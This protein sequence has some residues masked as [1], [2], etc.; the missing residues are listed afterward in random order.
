MPAWAAPAATTITLAITSSGDTVASGGSVASGSV[1]TLTARVNAGTTAVTV[2]QVNFCDAAATYCSDIHLLGTAQ[3]TSAGTAVLKFIPG[4][5]SHSYKAVFVGTTSNAESASIGSA[6]IVTG[7]YATMTGI[8]Q[9]GSGGDYSLMATVTGAGAVTPPT[10]MVSFLDA[11]NGNSVL[12]TAMLGTGTPGL[13]WLNSQTPAVGNFP[14]SV[15]VG[16]FNRD[17]IPDLAVA[18]GNDNTLTVL[19]GKGDGT[20][21]TQA[22]SPATGVA[23]ACI[24]VRDFNGDGIPDLAVSYLGNGPGGITILLGKGD[25]TFTTVAAS[26]ATGYAPYSIAVGDFNGDGIP[27]LAAANFESRTVTVLLGNGDG[28]F[29]AAASPA[30]GGDPESIAV[31]DFNGDGKDDLAVPNS[32]DSTVTILLGN[33]DGTFTTAASPITGDQPVCV[34]V[35]DFNGDGKADLAVANY[36]NGSYTDPST[37]TILLGNGDGTFTAATSPVTGYGPQFIA[38][39]D[40]NGDGVP[41]LAVANLESNTVTVLLGKGDGTFIPVMSPSTGWYPYSL[42]VGDFNGN[43]VPD[44]AV[45]N[46]G[47]NTATVL[48]TQLTQTAAATASGVSLSGSGSHAVEASFS[49]DNDYSASVSGTILVP[50]TATSTILAITSGG[51][52]VTTVASGSVVTLTATVTTGSAAL[53]T[54]W[55]DLCDATAVYCTDIHLLGTAQLTSAGTAVLSFVP[56]I[57][58]HS[59]KAVFV[60]TTGNAKSA[61]NASPL[62]VTGKHPTTTTITQSGTTGNYTLTATVTG[63]GASV[64]PTGTVSFLDTSDSNSVLAMAPLAA[65]TTGLNWVNSQASPVGGQPQSVAV[66]DFNRDGI[67]DIVVGNYETDNLTVLLGKGDG[68]FTAATSPATGSLPSG[69]VV[70]DFN[71]DGIPDMAVTNAA[72]PSQNFNASQSSVTVLLG[73]GDGTFTTG[74][75]LTAGVSPVSIATGDFNGDD[76]ADLAVV[77]QSSNTLTIFL[78]KGDGTFSATPISPATGANPTAVAVGDFNGDGI[79]DL[80]VANSGDDTVTV[81]IGNGD[82]TFTAATSPATGGRPD[83][84]A[85]GDFN[86]DGKIDLAVANSLDNTVMVLLSNG[87]GTFTAAPTT[88]VAVNSGGTIAVG[89]FNGDGILDLAVPIGGGNTVTVLLGNGDGT[90]TATTSA[91]AGDGPIAVAV[92]DFNGDG[93]GDLAVV[94]TYDETLSVLLVQTATATAVANNIS[95]LGAGSHAVTASYSDDVNYAASMSGATNLTGIAPPGFTL[96]STSVTLTPGATTGNTSTITIAPSGG[97][98]GNVTLTAAITSSPAGAQDLPT[99]SFGS[100]SPVSITGATAETAT[101]TVS[102]T[103]AAAATLARPIPPGD[104]SFT[105]AGAALACLLLFGIP[106]RRRSWRTTLGMLFFLAFL[107]GGVLS[108]GGVGGGGGGGGGSS[109]IANPGITAGTYTITVTGTSGTA[110][111]TGTVTLTVQ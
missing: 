15:A 61:S 67:P 56:G 5:G 43:G 75:T 63:A 22:V 78:G 81:L 39:G 24:V 42:A 74:P 48:L 31:G 91:V 58:S 54:G 108:C 47:G 35:G 105:A 1:V 30:T 44:L 60:G 107:T 88:S 69:L 79:P 11:S 50:P 85:T 10:G 62:T 95:P 96:G 52:A 7:K 92:G 109:G 49:G 110:T 2:G 33:G 32:F 101:L 18:N 73:K 51:G 9:S 27:D 6:L 21:T 89:D 90:F 13:Y 34:V 111:A 102:T 65:N 59:Y 17:G 26:A 100:T 38:L 87:N 104:R 86:D 53:K 28:T 29:K 4:I 97:F 80:A 14:V 16:D 12:G 8:A 66:A 84:I 76:K 3:L 77:N 37:L 72:V 83:S 20:F 82:G 41:D 19:L 98:T 40:F 94:N 46:Q 25:G 64:P 57:G 70:G 93:F 45:A 71:G 23:P 36:N 99:L 103:A 106:A 55:I 68:T